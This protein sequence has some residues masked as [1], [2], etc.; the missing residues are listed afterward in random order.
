MGALRL[1]HYPSPLVDQHTWTAMFIIAGSASLSAFR[2]TLRDLG[3]V[4]QFPN[5]GK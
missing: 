1:G 3:R 5:R 2:R 4:V